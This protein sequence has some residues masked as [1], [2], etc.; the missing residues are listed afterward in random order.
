MAFRKFFHT[1]AWLHAAG[2]IKQVLARTK[3]SGFSLQPFAGPCSFGYCVGVTV[4]W[5]A[6]AH[7]PCTAEISSSA[8]TTLLQEA[9]TATNDTFDYKLVTKLLPSGPEITVATGGAQQQ[10]EFFAKTTQFCEDQLQICMSDAESEVAQ[11]SNHAHGSRQFLDRKIKSTSIRLQL[12]GA[13]FPEIQNVM[14]AIYAWYE[15]HHYSEQNLWQ[16]IPCPETLQGGVVALKGKAVK[17]IFSDTPTKEVVAV[18]PDREANRMAPA[19]GVFGLGLLAV[20]C[21]FRCSL[22]SKKTDHA[23]V[24]TEDAEE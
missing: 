14:A 13:N 3:K 12:A 5:T 9:L 15:K 4:L 16:Y 10:S 2:E 8:N 1:V 19:A 21:A 11:R 24:A 7:F 17:Q 23:L 18:D 6:G 20:V 22:R